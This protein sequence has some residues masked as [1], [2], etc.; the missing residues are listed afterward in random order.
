ME[1]CVNS[2]KENTERELARHFGFRLMVWSIAGMLTVAVFALCRII[3]VYPSA[4]DQWLIWIFPLLVIRSFASG[5]IY[6][7]LKSS[8]NSL[9]L[10]VLTKISL[11][12][13]FFDG[14]LLLS[15]EILLFSIGEMSGANLI[16]MAMVSLS[17][18]ALGYS[19]S[20]RV[21]ILVVSV[22]TVPAL[23]LAFYKEIELPLEFLLAGFC[24]LA[25]TWL[26]ANRLNSIYL[27]QVSA[28]YEYQHEICKAAESNF[29]F[30]EHWQKMRV[31]AIDWDR[32]FVVRSW[33]PAAERLF[34]IAAERAIG[35]PLELLFDQE[36][37][38]EIRSNWVHSNDTCVGSAETRICRHAGKVLTTNWY[39]TPLFHD[40]E[41]IGIA[42]FV[43]EFGESKLSN[44]S[45]NSRIVR[46][47]VARIDQGAMD[48]DTGAT[49]DEDPVE[50]GKNWGGL[51]VR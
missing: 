36:S 45:R 14:M 40:D 43:I 33:N 34:G 42:S 44:E 8:I 30:N 23:L 38:A 18:I 29:I 39:D 1:L 31:A 19:F 3:K 24:V 25:G 48:S 5:L 50:T 49:A 26:G 15:A 32:D 13:G 9:S 20:P 22:V 16:F 6:R 10:P 28:K 46:K 7:N 51:P 12:S 2:V 35:Q 21:I 17:M 27:A 37:A 47:M 41:L 4:V 11:L